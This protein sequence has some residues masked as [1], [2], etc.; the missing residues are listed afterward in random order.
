VMVGPI[1]RPS[2]LE[3]IDGLVQRAAADG[4]RVLA[5]GHRLDFGKGYW[6]APTAVVDVDPTAEIARTEVFGPVLTVLKY[7]G[8]DDAAVR[9]ANDSPYGLSGYVQTSNPDRGWYIANRIRSGIVNI[10]PS[11]FFSSPDTPFGGRKLSGIGREGGDEGWR[12]FL[13][14]KTVAVA[15]P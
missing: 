6:F 9:A 2:Q 12:E 10:G 3:R 11:G 1:I 15:V 5:G 8:D 13:E 4:A 14:S 7:S